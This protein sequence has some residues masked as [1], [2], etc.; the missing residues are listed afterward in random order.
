MGGTVRIALAA[1]NA[2]AKV[3]T[4]SST[5]GAIYGEQDY[6]PADESHPCRGQPLRD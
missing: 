1:A 3:F 5:G 6:F 2:G 4:L